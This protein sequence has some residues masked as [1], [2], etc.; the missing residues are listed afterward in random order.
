MASGDGPTAVI[1]DGRRA[2][3]SFD[4]VD[5]GRFSFYTSLDKF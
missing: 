5:R 2:N 4:K 1:G 3:D